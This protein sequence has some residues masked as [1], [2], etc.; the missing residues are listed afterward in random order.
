[1]CQK[2]L[3]P[4]GQFRLRDVPRNPSCGLGSG[5]RLRLSS[6]YDPPFL[7]PYATLIFREF[8]VPRKLAGPGICQNIG[9]HNPRSS[10]PE[11]MKQ[12]H[13]LGEHI[14]PGG[15]LLAQVLAPGESVFYDS[16]TARDGIQCIFRTVTSIIDGLR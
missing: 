12:T 8:P 9:Q 15:Q 3:P 11:L 13:V 1:M 4:L 6:S 10:L 14:N 16:K 7:I 5:E 2:Q